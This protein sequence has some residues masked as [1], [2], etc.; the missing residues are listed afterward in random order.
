M[1]GFKALFLIL[2]L[3]AS[4]LSAQKPQLSLI[5]VYPGNAIYS[6][7]G[8]TAFRYVDDSQ[9]IDILYNFGTFDFRDPDFVPKFVH[10]KLDYFLGV[11][12]FKR[13]FVYYTHGENRT[14]V[15]QK[16]NLTQDEISRIHLFLAD[17]ALPENRYYKYD[18]IKDNCSTRIQRVLDGT[19]G[20]DLLYDQAVM[21]KIGEK[22][23]RDYIRC[24]LKKSPWYDVGIQLALGMP[25]DQKVLPSDS[26]FLP[27]LVHDIIAGSTLSD[28][29]PLVAGTEILYRSSD[30]PITDPL[31]DLI[32]DPIKINL[33]FLI[34]SLL[35]AAELVLIYLAGRK[36]WR[37][38]EKSLS[39]Y[40]YTLVVINFLFGVLVFY[41]WFISDHTATKWNLNLLWC[42]PLSLVFLVTFFLRGTGRTILK[43]ISIFMAFMGVLFLLILAVGI[44]EACSPFI[45]VMAL[46]IVLF[47][48][49]F[50]INLS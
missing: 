11:V 24:H 21:A 4:P 43:W 45:P 50:L 46:Y 6:A 17:N 47:G 30:D 44:Q 38:P 42:S 29:R 3:A 37:W 31:N 14:V 16:L 39:F 25:L 9:D 28:G 20:N 41:L 19:L 1:K 26:F 5:T 2:L 13:E 7:F 23:Y 8:H 40:E 18:F 15:E 48:R 22:S 36:K 33:P 49:R 35:L 12:K 10:G 34:F 27:A 32:N